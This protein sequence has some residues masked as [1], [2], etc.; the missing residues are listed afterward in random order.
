VFVTNGLYGADLGG[1]A[2]ADAK[3][4]EEARAAG[5]A[6]TYLAWLST[7]DV[8]A[9]PRFDREAGP[10]VL[11][12][13]EV[14]AADWNALV[15]GKD[16][17]HA[18]DRT[19]TRDEPVLSRGVT[20]CGGNLVWTSTRANGYYSGGDCAGWTSTTAQDFPSLGIAGATSRQWTD[21]CYENACGLEAHLY[22]VER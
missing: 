11:T 4:Q 18:I 10:F 21:W 5:L 2:G 14:V 13:G 6:G 22:C 9:A 15:S 17:V 20:K 8:N 1:I 19:P 12:T 7:S 16:L 3:C